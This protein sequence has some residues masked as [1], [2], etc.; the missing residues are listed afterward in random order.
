[1]N[2]DKVQIDVMTEDEYKGY[3]EKFHGKAYTE[4]ELLKE[5]EVVSQAYGGILCSKKGTEDLT[6]FNKAICPVG[7][8][9]FFV[10]VGG[11]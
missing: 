6:L 2:N 10:K 5:F 9:S 4:E 3:L 1:M 7:N 8:A 11:Y